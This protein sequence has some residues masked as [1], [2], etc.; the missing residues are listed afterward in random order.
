[1]KL[2]S[3]LFIV[4]LTLLSGF[5]VNLYA[6]EIKNSESLT[7]KEKISVIYRELIVD[8]YGAIS[9]NTQELQ[10]LHKFIVDSVGYWAKKFNLKTEEGL[11]DFGNMTGKR[12]NIP[13]GKKIILSFPDKD[14]N[15]VYYYLIS[16]GS[17]LY[18]LEKTN[19]MTR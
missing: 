6:Q 11:K 16:L 12:L 3:S 15:M 10:E 9:K 1:M 8:E 5:N 18:K 19:D 14:D 2:K 4:L 13:A 17:G 7:D